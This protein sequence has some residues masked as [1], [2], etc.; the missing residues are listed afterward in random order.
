MRVYESIISKCVKATGGACRDGDVLTG[1]MVDGS[2]GDTG[3][4]EF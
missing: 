2:G 4:G 3:M 1:W